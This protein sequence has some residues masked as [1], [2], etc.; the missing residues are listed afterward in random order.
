[1]PTLGVGL[2]DMADD[3][4]VASLALARRFSTGATMWC[5]APSW[6]A[7]AHH[8][9]VEF[10]HP[11]IMG[12]RALPAVAVSG[13][14][15]VRSLRAV[16]A[17]GDVVAAVAPTTDDAVLDA[18][19]RAPAWG[20]ETVWIGAGPR[21]TV[22][23]ADHVL[24]FDDADAL[25]A[26]KGRLVLVYHLLWELTHVCFE[27]PGLLSTTAEACDTTSGCITCG[28]EGRLAEIVSV[29]ADG[30]TATARTGRGSETVD[31]TLVG[32]V[33]PTDLVLVHGGS[34]ITRVE[35]LDSDPAGAR[36]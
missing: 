2:G 27:H 22:G 20:V 13:A 17:P 7:H 28:D 14:D 4:A 15:V 18:M 25:V 31:L 33:H 26:Y 21:P 10:V 35:A 36:S 23:A 9:A 29:D 1:M 3:L 32:E 12:K 16:V 30:L 34:A 8:L 5:L 24:W 19:R 6:P 11:V